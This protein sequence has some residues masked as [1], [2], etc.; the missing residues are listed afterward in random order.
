MLKRFHM[1][2]WSNHNLRALTQGRHA[3]LNFARS[4]KEA[5]FIS[6]LL[7]YVCEHKLDLDQIA[8]CFCAHSGIQVA[9]AMAENGKK[10]FRMKELAQWVAKQL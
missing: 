7:P 6:F 10:N 1:V 8:E 2:G 9:S 3:S 4:R 5:T